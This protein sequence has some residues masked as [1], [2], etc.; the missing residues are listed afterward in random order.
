[1]SPRDGTA[2][3]LMEPGLEAAPSSKFALSSQ[4]ARSWEHHQLEPSGRQNVTAA[5]RLRGPLDLPS[6]LRGLDA[7]TERHDLLRTAFPVDTGRPHQWVRP[8]APQELLIIDL[9]TDGH[10]AATRAAAAAARAFDLAT[11]PAWRTIVIRLGDHDHLLVLCAH[12]LVADAR[13]LRLLVRELLAARTAHDVPVQFAASATFA[14]AAREEDMRVRA[15]SYWHQRL[16]GLSR[17]ELPTASETSRRSARHALAFPDALCDELASLSQRLG[18]TLDVTLLALF[19]IL[20][21]RYTGQTDVAVGARCVR[22][23]SGESQL[24]GPLSSV[25]V[26]RADLS[27]TPTGIECVRRVDAVARAARLHHMPY[28]DLVEA[29]GLPPVPQALF[30]CEERPAVAAPHGVTAEWIEVDLGTATAPLSLEL[31]HDGSG[32]CG[33]LDYDRDLFDASTVARMADHLLRLAHGLVEDPG[34]PVALISMVT[35]AEHHELVSR[36][37]GSADL[38]VPNAP[39]HALFE[40]QVDRTPDAIALVWHEGVWTYRELDHRANQLARRLV[41]LGVAPQTPVCI[42]VDRSPEMIVALLGILKAGAAYVPMD[43]GYPR[44]RLAHVLRDTQTPLLVTQSVLV[45]SLPDR[46]VRTLCLDTEW[47]ADEDHERLAVDVSPSQLAY[48]IYTSGSTGKPK[49]VMIEHRA[50]VHYTIAATHAYDI[51]PSDCVAQFS[52]ISFDASVEE[53]FPTLTRGATL[54]LR[55]SSTLEPAPHFLAHCAER[56][57]TVLSLPTA[58]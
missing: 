52:S 4:Q 49:G 30:A 24:V 48:V 19:E 50:L 55:R 7:I 36:A 27:G 56:A 15:L 26:L 32:L 1:M 28:E 46:H 58:Y 45:P 22:T 11:G 42:Y 23:E 25:L 47:P 31:V 37:R 34:A 57:I 44:E 13:S 5:V 53:I 9:R 16:D 3:S 38:D 12:P 17:L 6:L 8:T 33:H 2:V 51:A 14:R 43:P 18:V 41:K 40:A 10:D 21:H 29:L 54:S 20:L 35:P 39:V